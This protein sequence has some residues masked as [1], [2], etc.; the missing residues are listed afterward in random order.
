MGVFGIL[1]STLLRSFIELF[2]H[3]FYYRGL[4]VFRFSL[5]MASKNFRFTIPIFPH[6]VGGYLFMY[7]DKLILDKHVPLA[8]IGIYAIAHNFSRLFKS[9]VNAYSNAVQPIIMTACKKSILEGSKTINK[10][11]KKWL[12]LIGVLFFIFSNYLGIVLK[13]LTPERLHSASNLIPILCGCYIFR[14]IYIYH[15]YTFYFM[16]KTMLI[17]IASIFSGI[18][19][20]LLNI[21]FIP[22]HQAYGAAFVT[23]F[24]F[25]VNLISFSFLTKYT[26]K[27]SLNYSSLFVL[28]LLVLLSI[29]TFLYLDDILILHQLIL[30][31]FILLCILFTIY[32]FNLGGLKSSIKKMRLA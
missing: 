31:T 23:L 3:F 2:L 10:E 21:I 9:V 12:I 8:I 5:K 14:G 28:G 17:S 6:A 30:K 1:L 4:F 26:F 27:I 22:S 15:L 16:E 7:S 32:F 13:I 29:L 20:V 25:F 24:C 11:S 18:L 19:N